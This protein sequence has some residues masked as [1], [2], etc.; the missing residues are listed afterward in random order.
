MCVYS[1]LNTDSRG[2]TTIAVSYSIRAREKETEKAQQC[3]FLSNGSVPLTGSAFMPATDL[4]YTLIE[5]TFLSI[6]RNPE[7][8]TCGNCECSN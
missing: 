3:A 6:S 5:E 4:A 2:L 7:G 8:P 1:A